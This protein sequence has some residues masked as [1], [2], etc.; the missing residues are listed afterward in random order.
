MWPSCARNWPATKP[1]SP[2]HSVNWRALDE[3]EDEHKVCYG[4]FVSDDQTQPEPGHVIALTYDEDTSQL[5]TLALQRL[6]VTDIV[7]AA[8]AVSE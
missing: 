6:A 7:T 8:R 1:C 5:R 2:T 3:T 4:L